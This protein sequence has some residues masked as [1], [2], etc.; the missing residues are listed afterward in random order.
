[1]KY[2]LSE[3]PKNPVIM[4]S[5]PSMGLISTITSK[6]L[7][8]HLEVK[9]IGYMESEHISPLTAIHKSEIVNP[10]TL[11]YNKEHNL[12]IVQCLTEMKGYEYEFANSL[13]DLAKELKAK[14]L[15]IV[16]GI[17]AQDS[18]QETSIF[19][20]TNKKSKKAGKI[21]PLTE[22]IVMGLTAALLLKA[23]EFPISC[24]FAEAHSNLP[25][26]EAA[27]KVV[28]GLNS[29]MKMTVDVNPL[30]EQAKKF[31][32]QLKQFLAKGQAP[33]IKPL[34][35]NLEEKEETNYVG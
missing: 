12:V 25:D 14:E 18:Q 10:I 9:Q 8:D 30:L 32:S 23:K 35:A 26:A 7:I 20:Y 3:R 2:F 6:F 11:F 31:E 27:A 29:Y 13:L 1:M 19:F 22:G 28:D 24:F 15:L 16:E 4:H 17:P 5:S 34:K 33:Q 21:K